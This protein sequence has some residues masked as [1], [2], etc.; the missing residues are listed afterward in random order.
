MSVWQPSY[1]NRA[2]LKKRIGK[3]VHQSPFPSSLFQVDHTDNLKMRLIKLN[4]SYNTVAFNTAKEIRR[5]C[6]R[7]VSSAFDKLTDLI[8]SYKSQ[9]IDELKSSDNLRGLIQFVQEHVDPLCLALQERHEDFFGL[10]SK[11]SEEAAK[12]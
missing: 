2:L 10:I 3:V 12:T 7:T 6:I 5:H 4:E 8:M 1:E 11:E 9:A